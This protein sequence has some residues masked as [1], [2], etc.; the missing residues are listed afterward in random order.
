VKDNPTVAVQ[1]VQ[2]QHTG[3]TA[4]ADNLEDFPQAKIF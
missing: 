4:Q 2:L 3:F 1:A